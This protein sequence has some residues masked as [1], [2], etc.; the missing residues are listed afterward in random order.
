MN[1]SPILFAIN[2]LDKY[3]YQ[4]G[5]SRRPL[6]KL[7]IYNANE[8]KITIAIAFCSQNFKVPG[9]D[10]ISLKILFRNPK[11]IPSSESFIRIFIFI[12]I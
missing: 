9:A 11:I 8:L 2:N 10:V 7:S 1:S 4:K 12:I 6:C 3:S 5:G